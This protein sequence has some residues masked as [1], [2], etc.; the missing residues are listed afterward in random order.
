MT[1][2]VKRDTAPGH[3]D[4]AGQTT[5]NREQRKLTKPEAGFQE[6][7]G[8][9]ELRC[10]DCHY[11]A[12][13]SCRIVEGP[14]D[15]DDIC[16]Q[17]EPARGQGNMSSQVATAVAK[18]TDDLPNVQMFISRVSENPQTGVR[19]WFATAS[20]VKRD[21]YEER[22][23]VGLF[24]DFIRRAETREPAP[25]PF[26]SEAWKGGLP[27]L[28]V[29]HYLDLEGYGIVGPTERIWVDGS[30]FK[31]KGTF[32]DTPLAI[33]T[34][35][36]IKRDIEQD[37]P[38]DERV[39]ISIA[40]IDY[41]H[42]HQGHG[43]FERKSLMDTCPLCT[44]GIGEKVYKSGHLVH[45]AT[46]RRPAYVET[47]IGLEERSTMATRREDAASIV[48]E[49]LA[50]E[51]EKRQL[52]SL[53]ERSEASEG[54]DP[55]AIVVK[56]GE[57]EEEAVS[58]GT[59]GKDD[60]EGEYKSMTLGGAVSLDEAEKVLAER[61]DSAPFMDQWDVLGIVLGNIAG[62]DK[63]EQV[64]GVLRD[65]QNQVDVMTAKAVININNMLDSEAQAAQPAPAT[66]EAG[67]HPSAIEE[68]AVAEQEHPLNDALAGLM[69]AYDEAAATPLDQ[70]SRLAM[71][72]PAMNAVGEVIARS[73]SQPAQAAGD[74]ASGGV[75]ANML[76]RI[77]QEAVAPLQADIA[78]LKAASTVE[79]IAP[80]SPTIP[81]PRG[82]RPVNPA[83]VRRVAAAGS[84]GQQP[85][86]AGG[87]R[88]FVRRSVGL[89]E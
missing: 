39:R 86:K 21:R 15:A 44:A 76:A 13:D 67:V 43:D 12:G 73:I 66:V 34:F 2:A 18:A 68:V 78:S 31:A 36:A 40:F 64:N 38:Q 28:G 4:N 65:F 23:S 54:I 6:R 3:K 10:G 7:G 32:E 17:F 8:I 22:M 11:F 51:L 72:Q 57:D 42:Q 35:D 89:S 79:R 88:S 83:A 52:K 71:I 45:L 50:D 87:L 75:D 69:D 55:R 85:A 84:G 25:E 24:K 5:L 29:A 49:E 56:Q 26:T 27:Y 62:P 58:T 63:A 41:G 82:L 48:G 19:R 30:V 53:T 74:G 60:G 70:K 14:I 81:A 9:P 46:T 80:V 61:S 47:S 33:A 77:V 16:N 1:N 37:V 20:G 59:A